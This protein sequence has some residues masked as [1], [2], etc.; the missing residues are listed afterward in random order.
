MESPV[1]HTHT[2]KIII[3][4]IHPVVMRAKG[5]GSEEEA[6]GTDAGNPDFPGGLGKGH[7]NISD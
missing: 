3:I 4:Q 2:H 1:P 6:A 7:L 5:R